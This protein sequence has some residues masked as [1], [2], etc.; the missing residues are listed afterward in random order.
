MSDLSNK[1]INIAGNIHPTK[2]Q[3]Y[4][5]IITLFTNTIQNDGGRGTYFIVGS[6]PKLTTCIKIKNNLIN[7]YGINSNNINIIETCHWN[8]LGPTVDITKKDS[9]KKDS[10]K[11]DSTKKDSTKNENNEKENNEQE[12]DEQENNEKENDEQENDEQD[13]DE[14]S[15]I[16]QYIYKVYL[17]IKNKIQMENS[18]KEFHLYEERFQKSL[19]DLKNKN[20]EYPE[21]KDKWIPF[22]SKKMEESGEKDVMTQIL[23][24]YKKL[25]L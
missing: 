25:Q 24:E 13:N 7:E 12:N 17:T 20:R 3:E 5:V 19:E 23:E 8:P 4:T 16:N 9:T 15:S 6:F 21:L 10:T 11:K 2:E 18:K 1:I 14:N 22:F